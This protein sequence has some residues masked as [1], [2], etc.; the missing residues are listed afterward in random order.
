M[1]C[2]NWNYWHHV[3]L[4]NIKFFQN[5]S[6]N[7]KAPLVGCISLAKNSKCCQPEH[8]LCHHSRQVILS[9]LCW[10]KTWQGNIP[11]NILAMHLRAVLSVTYWKLPYSITGLPFSFGPNKFLIMVSSSPKF[12]DR[13]FRKSAFSACERIPPIGEQWVCG[14]SSAFAAHWPF[15]VWAAGN[16]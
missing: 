1:K 11:L 6:Q 12:N 8:W 16:L 5:K 7:F 2:I 10:W 15:Q 14:R 13:L 4:A 9:H 3:K